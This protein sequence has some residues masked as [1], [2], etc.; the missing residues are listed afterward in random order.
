MHSTTFGFVHVGSAATVAMLALWAAEAGAAEKSTAAA[1]GLVVGGWAGTAVSEALT[2]RVDRGGGIVLYAEDTAPYALL[3][4]L[5][6]LALSPLAFAAI[7]FGAALSTAFQTMLELMLCAATAAWLG[8]DVVV[9][10]A[11]RRLSASA[12]PLHVQW[13]DG[14]SA[15]GP[16]AMLGRAG[17]VTARCAPAG[18]VRI[19]GELWR[20]E[21]VDGSPLAAGQQVRV[22]RLKGL[23]LLVE[24]HDDGPR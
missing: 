6:S 9:A 20:A 24:A 21:S 18:G 10:R 16:E 12:R 5:T 7:V 17:V 8:H 4:P 23:L 19:G 15:V 3:W 22:V 1:A 13:F 14:R 11:L 2:R